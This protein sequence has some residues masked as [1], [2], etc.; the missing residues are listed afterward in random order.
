V[1]HSFVFSNLFGCACDLLSFSSLYFLGSGWPLWQLSSCCP[2]L[3]TNVFL[4]AL[5]LPCAVRSL[6]FSA[7]ICYPSLQIWASFLVSIP[8][9]LQFGCFL[10]KSVFT[11]LLSTS[12]EFLGSH[13]ALHFLQ[14]GLRVFLDVPYHLWCACFFPF[15]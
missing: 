9:P 4:Y 11:S 6:W 14:A 13:P 10:W 8:D 15:R 1:V 2:C 5:P 12:L 7:F 3:L